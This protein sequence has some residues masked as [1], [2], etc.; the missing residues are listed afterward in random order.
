MSAWICTKCGRKWEHKA[1]N[2]E[3]PDKPWEAEA[4]PG[5]YHSSK[6]PDLGF[7]CELC[8]SSEADLDMMVRFTKDHGLVTEA[9]DSI[10][11]EY[12]RGTIAPEFHGVL[13]QMV[14]SGENES[15]T[16]FLRDYIIDEHECS[17]V[18]WARG[19]HRGI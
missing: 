18:E 19:D 5:H 1:V 11:S 8:A 14:C 4:F 2:A 10:F 13:W 7:G 6:E 3:F 12:G 9:V 15:C 17:F 16:T